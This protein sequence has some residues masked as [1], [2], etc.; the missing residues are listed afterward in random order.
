M[1][2]IKAVKSKRWLEPV[3]IFI[4]WLFIGSA[5]IGIHLGHVQWFIPKTPIN[6]LIG[7]VL[8]ALVLPMS[9]AKQWLAFITAFVVGMGVEIAGVATG[10]IF[11]IYSYGSNLGPKLLDVP[12]MIGVYWAVLTF[13][14]SMIARRYARRQYV[15]AAV[16]AGLMVALDLLLE[17][18]SCP[19]DF[20]CFEGDYAPLRNYVAWYVTALALHMVTLRLVP[21]LGAERYSRH[22]FMSQA[23]FMVYLYWLLRT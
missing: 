12:Y 9:T 19:L 5:I 20:W 14:T 21:D 16:G 11:G 8:L 1:L 4:V 3:A 7:A 23:L 13:V 18:V 17:Q 6:L 10:K 2:Q 22:L 15:V